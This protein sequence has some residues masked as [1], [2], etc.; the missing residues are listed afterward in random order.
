M[1]QIIAGHYLFPFMKDIS[2]YG[3]TRH[4]VTAITECLRELMG[5]T[6]LP[7]RVTSISPGAVET[8]MTANLRKLELNML[9]FIDIA[10]AVIHALSAPQR[11]N[12]P[13]YYI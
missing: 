10:E 7:I 2:V 1:V 9:K 6:I 4:S 11:V 13:S 3:A 8:E 5:M 12:I